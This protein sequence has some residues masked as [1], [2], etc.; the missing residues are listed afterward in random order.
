MKFRLT[1]LNIITALGFVLLVFLL[2][3]PKQS[4]PQLLKMN[5]FY[6]L[7]I[8]CLIAATFISDLIFRF[9]LKDLKK[10]WIV[11]LAFIVLTTIL[12]LILQK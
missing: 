1:P 8:G 11:E 2:L 9:I 3:Q 4:A 6:F 7:I 10:I 5:P 12:I